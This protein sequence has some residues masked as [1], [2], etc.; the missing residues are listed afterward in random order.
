MAKE[1][2]IPWTKLHPWMKAAHDFATANQGYFAVEIG[3]EE[4]K[5]WATYFQEMGWAPWAFRDLARCPIDGETREWTAP[6]RWPEW[7]VIDIEA[8]RRELRAA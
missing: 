6:C 7:L 4:Y 1:K 5:S 3:S 2:T 8:T